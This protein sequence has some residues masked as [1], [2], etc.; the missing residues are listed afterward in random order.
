[1]FQWVSDGVHW[2]SNG[3]PYGWPNA[4]RFVHL[5]MEWSDGCP[6]ETTKGPMAGPMGGFGDPWWSRW[7]WR[8]FWRTNRIGDPFGGPMGGFGDPFGGPGG[9]GDPLV[10]QVDL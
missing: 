4:G 9:F 6:T 3:R 2:C 8:S 1:M 7:I 5:L 10:V